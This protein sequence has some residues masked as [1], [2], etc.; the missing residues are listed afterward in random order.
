MTRAARCMRHAYAAQ[1]VRHAYAA[2]CVRHAYAAQCMRQPA[3]T[4]AH[5]LQRTN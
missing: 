3:S 4:I 1:C 5:G 2:Q